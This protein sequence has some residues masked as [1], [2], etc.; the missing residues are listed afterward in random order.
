M[1][2]TTFFN[3]G[4]AGFLV[5]F[6]LGAYLWEMVFGTLIPAFATGS[7]YPVGGAVSGPLALGWWAL[8]IWL[9]SK[10]GAE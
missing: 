5:V 9:D 10:R 4:L 7:I 2:T 3:I 1:K 6:I 8:M